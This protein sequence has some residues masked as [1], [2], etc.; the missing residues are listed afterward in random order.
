MDRDIYEVWT[1][2]AE[3]LAEIGRYL[4]DHSTKVTVRLPKPLA[5]QALERWQR[6]DGGQPPA[7]ETPEQRATRYK[8]AKPAHRPPAAPAPDQIHQD[9]ES[10]RVT[11]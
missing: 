7:S 4:L 11:A 3:V 6:E 2:D 10:L 1:G 8:A 9:Q 5:Q